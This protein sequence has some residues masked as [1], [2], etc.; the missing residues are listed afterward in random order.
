M[1]ANAKAIK[2]QAEEVRARRQGRLRDLGLQPADDFSDG[3][4]VWTE[5]FG[6]TNVLTRKPVTPGST[7]KAV[8][9]AAAIEAGI[10]GPETTF[11]DPVVYGLPGSTATIGNADGAP[12]GDGVSVTLQTAV[13]RSCNTVFAELSVRVGAGAIGQTATSFGFSVNIFFTD[14]R[15]LNEARSVF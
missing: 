9:A 7:F 11:D 1:A 6:V 10:A 15:S 5:G 8:V 13:V 14:S 2:D 12:C 3:R 4:V